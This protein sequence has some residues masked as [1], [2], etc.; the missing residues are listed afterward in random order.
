[1]GPAY[2]MLVLDVPVVLPESH[3]GEPLEDTFICAGARNGQ[4]LVP[5]GPTTECLHSLTLQRANGHSMYLPDKP[6]GS[7]RA[8]D[9]SEPRRTEATAHLFQEGS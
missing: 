1:M 4:M 7:V 9:G 2:A 3:T 8:A 6:S 5:Y